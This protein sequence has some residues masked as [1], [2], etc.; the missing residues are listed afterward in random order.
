MKK[1]AKQARDDEK[2]LNKDA[3]ATGAASGTK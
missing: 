2:Q 3:N 1:D